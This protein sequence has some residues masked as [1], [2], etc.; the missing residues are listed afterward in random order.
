M[1]ARIPFP[2]TL[3]DADAWISSIGAGEFVRGIEHDG[4]LIG[5]CGYV[6]DEAGVAE[7][8][9]WIGRAYW[10]RG[11]ATEAAR[12]I[13]TYCFG[14]CGYKR[15]ACSHFADNPASRR[16]IEKLGF[17][18]IGPGIGWCEAR[19]SET[20]TVRYEQR[21]TWRGFLARRAA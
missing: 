1:T 7:I 13:V 16:V 14:P 2:Y 21:R 15:L 18:R 20:P 6:I 10:G 4:T 17:R 8:G 19:Q 11:F 12:A 9:Y 5:A 3:L